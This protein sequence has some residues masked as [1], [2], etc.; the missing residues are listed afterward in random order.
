[1]SWGSVHYYKVQQQQEQEQEQ[2]QQ[3]YHG[4]DFTNTVALRRLILSL[5]VVHW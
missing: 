1:M 5:V 2:Q 3:G 4:R